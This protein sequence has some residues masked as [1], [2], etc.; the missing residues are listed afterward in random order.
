M[1]YFLGYYFEDILNLD[2]KGK[3]HRIPNLKPKNKDRKNKILSLW[4]DRKYRSL[5]ENNCLYSQKTFATTISKNTDIN[6][7]DRHYS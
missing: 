6:K 4:I 3:D 7:L 1:T 2:N 5:D